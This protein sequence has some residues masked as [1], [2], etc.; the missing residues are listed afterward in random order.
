MGAS[1]PE[2]P[3][4]SYASLLRDRRFLP[5]F[6]AQSAGDAG[7][8]IYAVSIPWLAYHTGGPVA[9]GLALFVEFAVY[10][11]SFAAGPIVDRVD[12]LR[13]LLVV[14]YA[15]QAFLAAVLGVLA[16]R[17]ELT[18]ASLLAVLIPLSAIWDF[19]WTATNVAPPRIVR[20]EDLLRANGLLGAVSGGN[21]IAGYAAGAGLLLLVGPA[22]GLFLYAG[23]NAVAGVLALAVHAP[24]PPGFVP[25][26][27]ASFREGWAYFLRGPG[28][29]RLQISA[30]SAAEAFVSAAP[31]LLLTVLAA[32]AVTDPSGTYATTFAAFALGGVFGSLFLG[33]F[34]PRRRLGWVLA[35]VAA[36]EAPL[37]I[38]V[39]ATAGWGAWSAPIWAVLGAVDV[40][41][42]SVLLVYFQA[43]SPPALVGR[44]VANAYLFRGLAR[45]GGILALAAVLT[46]SSPA[47]LAAG[48][49]VALVAIAVASLALPAVRGMGF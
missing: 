11:L 27:Q 37:I 12:D 46:V 18:V 16:I 7:Y 5:F 20:P 43:T 42:Y 10:S 6:L 39:V 32:R 23:L 24:R 36:T 34:A 8:A 4:R 38:L 1:A 28:R 3:R 30:A 14:G 41:F 9:L 35:V 17:E 29:P 22:G 15:A 45:A 21:Q 26:F 48:V 19:T 44:T 31:V 25:R 47:S 13:T 49:A 40:T 33:Q 2:L